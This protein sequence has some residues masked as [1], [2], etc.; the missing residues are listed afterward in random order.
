MRILTILCFFLSFI[1]F[2]SAYSPFRYYPRTTLILAAGKNDVIVQNL[3]TQEKIT[4]QAGE[5]LSL[6]AF[7]TGTR[8]SFQCKQGS[9]GSCEILLDGKVV[10]SCIENIPAKKS[11]TISKVKR[12]N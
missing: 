7:K 5:S 3:D 8:L 11:I 10:R 6:A 1:F 9:C 2:C 12:K 4:M